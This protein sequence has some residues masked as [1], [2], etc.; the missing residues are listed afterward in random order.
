MPNGGSRIFE[1]ALVLQATGTTAGVYDLQLVAQGGRLA[2][3]ELKNGVGIPLGDSQKKL[4]P[5]LDHLGIPNYLA[6]DLLEFQ[7]AVCHHLG[8]ELAPYL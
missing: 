3:I 8:V 1:E 2:M 4:K 5:R 7:Q 6:G